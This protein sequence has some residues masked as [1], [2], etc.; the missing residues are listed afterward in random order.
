[1]YTVMGWPLWLRGIL[2]GAVFAAAWAIGALVAGEGWGQ[3]AI[4]LAGGVTFAIGTTRAT[5]RSEKGLN[6]PDGPA[7]NSDERVEAYRAAGHGRPS[8]NPRVQAAALTLARQLVDR[9]GRLAVLAVSFGFCVMVT[10]VFAVLGSPRWWSVT[11]IFVAG[12]VPAF[13]TLGRQRKR[14]IALLAASPQ[15]PH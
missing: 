8:T 1:M 15:V 6:P 11:A 14:A 10:V 12:G 4:G 2:N 9:R 3:A 13:I 5:A 7:L